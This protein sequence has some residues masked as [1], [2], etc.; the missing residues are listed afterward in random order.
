MNK[1]IGR[2]I[3]SYWARTAGQIVVH[4]LVTSGATFSPE[5]VREDVVTATSAE[6]RNSTTTQFDSAVGWA[7]HWLLICD[8]IERVAYGTYRLKERVNQNVAIYQVYSTFLERSRQRRRNQKKG[9]KM[10]SKKKA[11]PETTV[12]Y[13]GSIK[14]VKLSR[15]MQ[16][17][18]A[19]GE[20]RSFRQ[21]YDLDQALDCGNKMIALA[22]HGKRYLHQQKPKTK[23]RTKLEP[24]TKIIVTTYCCGDITILGR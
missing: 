1:K 18:H 13:V 14:G 21:E 24:V 4:P 8:I 9:K 12:E 2:K 11:L 15:E 5:D 6:L 10:K 20:R 7:L 22:M 16:E 17:A 3:N 19:R 23:I